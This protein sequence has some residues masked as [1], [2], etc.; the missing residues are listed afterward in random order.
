MSKGKKKRSRKD[1][2]NDDIRAVLSYNKVCIVRLDDPINFQTTFHHI[3]G[4]RIE[5]SDWI[6]KALNNVPHKWTF[7]QAAFCNSGR[8]E[9]TK[10]HEVE[11][12]QYRMVDTIKKQV[13]SFRQ[14]L[15]DDCNPNHLRMTGMISLPYPVELSQEQADHLFTAAF[16]LSQAYYNVD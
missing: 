1:R 7:F 8:Q 5:A 14:T 6:I 12:K 10:A 11:F 9:Y 15:V 3:S 2:V 4:K 13:M 16:E